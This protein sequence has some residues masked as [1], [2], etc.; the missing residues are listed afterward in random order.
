MDILLN[1]RPYE[2][3]IL[4]VASV[5]ALLWWRHK[6]QRRLRDLWTACV[7]VPA[8]IVLC[9]TCIWVGYYNYRVTGK[10]WL[11]PYV[12]NQMTYAAAPH[13]WFLPE[14]SSPVY[15]HEVL[16]KFWTE[17]DRDFYLKTR[18]NPVRILLE[19]AI[20]DQ[21]VTISLKQKL[22]D[23]G[24]CRPL[25]L[26]FLGFFSPI[27]SFTIYRHLKITLVPVARGAIDFL[28]L[29]EAWRTTIR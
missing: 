7:I 24:F 15:R 12:A 25:I 18:A 21:G 4:T 22:L 20:T 10:A 2:G 13:F 23:V 16:R 5:V 11:M 14:G 19:T 9:F 3:F 27:P 1:T 26:Q 17:W 6:A 8:G 28:Q 29:H